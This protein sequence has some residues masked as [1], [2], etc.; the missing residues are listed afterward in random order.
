MWKAVLT[1]M[2]SLTGN[3]DM[4]F[5]VFNKKEIRYSPNNILIHIYFSDILN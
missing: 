3:I 2:L 1:L 5:F 4:Q